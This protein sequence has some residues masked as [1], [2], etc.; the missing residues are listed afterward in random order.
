[1]HPQVGGRVAAGPLALDV[2]RLVRAE[3]RDGAALFTSIGA[4]RVA[5]SRAP[6][7]GGGSTAAADSRL[8]V[9]SA[10]VR[11]WLRTLNEWRN[12]YDLDGRR[13]IGARDSTSTEATSN[14]KASGDSAS[15]AATMVLVADDGLRLRPRTD[16]DCEYPSFELDGWKVKR[17]ANTRNLSLSRPLTIDGQRVDQQLFEDEVFEEGQ[18]SFDHVRHVAL[19]GAGRLVVQTSRTVERLVV[20]E[21]GRPELQVAALSGSPFEFLTPA[22]TVELRRADDERSRTVSFE[23]DGRRL[24][25][26]VP[27]SNLADENAGGGDSRG[28]E[29]TRGRRLPRAF[30]H[31]ERIWVIDP[32]GVSWVE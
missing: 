29:G 19:D 22:G 11:D 31:G 21:D 4:Y 17:D 5:D 1:M 28:D 27:R 15:P 3:A 16:V 2:V 32:S 20:G 10:E 9:A 6:S 25:V 12:L 24:H 26:P 8:E 23:C 7:T 30:A 13:S 18:M 14:I